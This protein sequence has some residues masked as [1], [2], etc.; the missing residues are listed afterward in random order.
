[1][2]TSPIS[3]I[4][5]N[6]GWIAQRARPA[7]AVGCIGVT[8]ALAAATVVKLW[9][10]QFLPLDYE[11]KL[12]WGAALITGISVVMAAFMCAIIAGVPTLCAWRSLPKGIKAAGMAPATLILI[13]WLLL[14]TFTGM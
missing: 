7:I 14:I 1:M 2:K 11:G 13:V 8:F 5:Q 6:A 4:R 10:T 12:T 9:G 3:L